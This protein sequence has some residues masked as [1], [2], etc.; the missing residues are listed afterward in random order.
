MMAAHGIPVSAQE[1]IICRRK[2]RFIA[3]TQCSAR[4]A[5][6]AASSCCHRVSRYLPH[7]AG[8]ASAAASISYIKKLLLLLL[9]QQHAAA[10]CSSRALILLLHLYLLAF[11]KFFSKL[12]IIFFFLQFN[13]F[14]FCITILGVILYITIGSDAYLRDSSRCLVLKSTTDQNMFATVLYLYH[15]THNKYCEIIVLVPSDAQ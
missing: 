6:A 15:R 2:D 11:F 7:I 13:F 12:N 5:S 10:P 1:M 14:L 3:C 9:P 4:N 8:A